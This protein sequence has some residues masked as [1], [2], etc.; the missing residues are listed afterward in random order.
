[1][2]H[3]LRCSLYRAT[4]CWSRKWRVR[5]RKS[6][7][8]GLGPPSESD[9]PWQVIGCRR[10]SSPRASPNLPPTPSQLSGAHSRKSNAPS[11]ADCRASSSPRR[12]PIPALAG[13]GRRR[14]LPVGSVV[15]ATLAL[16]TLAFGVGLAAVAGL[17]VG[18]LGIVGIGR[19]GLVVAA[20]LAF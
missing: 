16:A 18:G 2:L 17:V 1:S 12:R 3:Q 11:G 13:A 14:R 7:S 4:R 10:E 9:R 19:R 15:T 5:W 20:A 6:I 8:S